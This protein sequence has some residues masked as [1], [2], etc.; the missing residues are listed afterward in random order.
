MNMRYFCQIYPRSCFENVNPLRRL[1]E[2]LA[3]EK[4][5]AA[6]AVTAYGSLQMPGW[7]DFAKALETYQHP[8]V[9]L[10]VDSIVSSVLSSGFYF[11]SQDHSAKEKVERWSEKVGF[12]GLLFEV[13]KELVLCGNSFLISEGS[14]EDLQLYRIP[15]T[16]FRPKLDLTLDD[17]LKVRIVNYYLQVKVGPQVREVRLP[18]E[19]VIHLAFNVLDPSWP[20]GVGLAYQLI[21][22]RRDMLGREA[23]SPFEAEAALMRALI[24]YLL[25]A[26]PKRLFYFNVDKT[27]LIEEIKPELQDILLDPPLDFITNEKF[28]ITDVKA[29][30]DLKWEFYDIFGNQFV[31]AL[32]SPVV[33]LFT[34]PGFTEASAREATNVWE[35]YVNALREHVEH[36]IETQIIPKVVGSSAKVEIHW[37]QPVR[38]ELEFNQIIAAAKAD[39]YNAAIVTR[40]EARRMLRELG[41]M[42]EEE[43]AKPSIESFVFYSPQGRARVVDTLHQV[44]IYTADIDDIDKSTIRYYTIDADKGI[45]IAA[46]WVK[47]ERRRRIVA[48]FFDKK[49]YDWTPD[50]ARDYYLSTFPAVIEKLRIPEPL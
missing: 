26:V 45:S 32:R 43:P 2:I 20:W 36:V 4:E 48:I 24:A 8:M 38:P 37:G 18:A 19:Q 47:S 29:P 30:G 7:P 31:A 5:I 6:E 46:A 41:W 12:R 44:E 14:G 34:T 23:P 1:A 27:K 16:W 21:S 10:A 35:L 25:K 15:L 49:L 42:L 33:K 3:G 50:K 40:E 17:L 28:E 39:A 22:R 13:V 9:A 11:T